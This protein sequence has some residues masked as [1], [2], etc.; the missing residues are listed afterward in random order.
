[1]QPADA[2]KLIFQNEFGGGHLI[3]DE[4][5]CLAYLRREYAGVVRDP[6]L[7]RIESIGNGILRVNLAALQES[8][9][10][11]LGQ[12]FIRS[13]AAHKGSPDVFLA[14]LTVLKELTREGLFS[15]GIRELEAY[16]QDYAEKGYPPVSHSPEYRKHYAPAYRIVL[17]KEFTD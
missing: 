17:E 15:F 8:D 16:L 1:M 3:V 10:E 13:A 6:A 12:C 2:V 11:K 9:V 4:E 5:A 7:A 14:K